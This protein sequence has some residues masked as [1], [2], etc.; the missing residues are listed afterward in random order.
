LIDEAARPVPPVFALAERHQ[1][2][3]RLF[4][5][6]PSIACTQKG[7]LWA[8]W[9]SGG[10]G[11]SPLNFVLAARSKDG[12]VSWGNQLVI[13]PPGKVRAAD[14]LLWLDP[15][16]RL[17]LFWMQSH[18]LHDG[19]N[20]VWFIRNDHPDQPE[21]KWSAPRR[22]CDGVLLNKPA[23]FQDGS[24]N[25][26]VSR[27]TSHYLGNEFR[28]LPGFLRTGLLDLVSTEEKEAIDRK[29][30]AFL[31][32]SSDHGETFVEIGVCK[33]P[34]A[35]STHNE[36]AFVQLGD[37][38]LWMLL[39]TTYGIARS[40]SSNHGK[41]WTTAEPTG[42]PH[43]SSRFFFGRL[44]SGA[45]L[46]IKHRE[47]SPAGFSLEKTKYKRDRLTAFLSDDD[48]KSWS[49]GLLLH[50][51]L[52]SYPDVCEDGKGD[53]HIIFDRE[54][55]LEREV[56]RLTLREEDL[57]AGRVHDQSSLKPVLI[58]KGTGILKPEEDWAQ[59]KGRDAAEAPLI[60]TGI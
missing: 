15:L 39:R 48:G 53:I 21:A 57:R 56:L 44:R 24:W 59:W 31:Y 60:F 13:D 16:N 47:L 14:P 10:Q 1:E 17:W 29:A 42:W 11:E 55:R 2:N 43:P 9:Y 37:G 6:I 54:R 18:T 49:D 5:G 8:A 52:C 33:V 4:Q 30:G 38:T 51:G 50:E 45:L 23:I 12:G 22:I 7:D 46:F 3:Q 20:G 28:M 34:D 19:R 32:R 27:L 25:F 35:Y 36:H 41:D 40:F 26:P 58:S